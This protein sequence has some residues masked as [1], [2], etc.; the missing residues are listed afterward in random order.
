[1]ATLKLYPQLW[2]TWLF[3]PIVKLGR[4]PPRCTS[5]ER[6]TVDEEVIGAPVVVLGLAQQPSS[7]R[8]PPILRRIKHSSFNAVVHVDKSGARILY[9]TKFMKMIRTGRRNQ[10]QA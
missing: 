3:T 5:V 9:P 7:A 10:R 1:M 2:S 6:S 8:V 4:W